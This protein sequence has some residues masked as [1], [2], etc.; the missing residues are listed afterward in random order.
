MTGHQNNAD[1]AVAMKK[2]GSSGADSLGGRRLRSSIAQI[3]G[4]RRFSCRHAKW[5][6]CGI[7]YPPVW[8]PFR[9]RVAIGVAVDELPASQWHPDAPADCSFVG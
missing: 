7:A 1:E 9:R 5:P 4:E 2:S 6:A 8:L 3:P